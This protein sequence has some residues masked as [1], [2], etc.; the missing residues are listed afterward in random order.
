MIGAVDVWVQRLDLGLFGAPSQKTIKLYCNRSFVNELPGYIVRDWFPKSV[1]VTNT[2]VN[3]NGEKQVTGGDGLKETQTYPVLFGAAVAMWYRSHFPHLFK[4]GVR[5][6]GQHA[7]EIDFDVF[8]GDA[9]HEWH[10]ADLDG[11]FDKV[12]HIVKCRFDDM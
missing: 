5:T 4:Q 10:A 1:G 6:R 9:G 2:T 3:A 8:C 7:T 11:V 12:M